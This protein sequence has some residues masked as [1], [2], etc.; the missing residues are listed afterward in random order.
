M[1]FEIRFS[2]SSCLCGF[3]YV[4]CIFCHSILFEQKYTVDVLL[5]T[6]TGYKK[7]GPCVSEQLRKYLD[8]PMFFKM[9]KAPTPPPPHS[10]PKNK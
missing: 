9:P 5:C 6:T 7:E 10:P 2:D 3:F 4:M 1:P 8:L